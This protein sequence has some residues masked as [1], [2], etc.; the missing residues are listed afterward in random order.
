M[1]NEHYHTVAEVAEKL[2]RHPRT[3][4]DW[5]VDGCKTERGHVR[6]EATKVGKS[7]L[8]HADWLALFEHRIR[9]VRRADLDLE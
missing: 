7:W 5:I 8:I 4:R 6:L 3:I 1:P 2:R 9:P